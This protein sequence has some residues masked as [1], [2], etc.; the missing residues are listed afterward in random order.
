MLQ[1]VHLQF[2]TRG[3]CHHH[4]VPSTDRHVLFLSP[5]DASGAAFSGSVKKHAF[6]VPHHRVPFAIDRQ[7]SRGTTLLVQDHTLNQLL[8]LVFLNVQIGVGDHS[9]L[10][11]HVQPNPSVAA[12][13]S[14]VAST[15]GGRNR[16]CTLVG[17]F[18]QAD[19][20]W[21]SRNLVE[22][23]L[24]KA[25]VGKEVVKLVTVVIMG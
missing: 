16:S 19:D 3:L 17:G 4:H 20:V 7:T 18:E 24:G 10:G 25:W 1:I 8:V 12:L 13:V 14:I 15:P 5:A 23:G 22:K 9:V 2:G 11:T 21:Q 6:L